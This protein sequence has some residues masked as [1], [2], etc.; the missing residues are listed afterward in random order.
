MMK[1]KNNTSS[2]CVLAGVLFF[3]CAMPSIS[4]AAFLPMP[5]SPS[6]RPSLSTHHPYHHH[7]S[8]AAL[9]STRRFNFFKDMLEKAFEN[10]DN[11]SKDEKLKGQIDAAPEKDDPRRQEN[12]KRSKK[13]LTATQEKWRNAVYG[14]GNQNSAAAAAA[15]TTKQASRSSPPRSFILI[16]GQTYLME[17]FLT[18]VP[19]KDP[20]SDLFGSKVNISSRD[21]QVGL[22]VPEKPSVSDVLIE[23]LPNEKCRC[24]TDTDFTTK[25][26]AAANTGDDDESNGDSGGY[27]DWKLSSDGKQI[28]FRIP[29]QGYTRTVETRGSIQ[30]VYWSNEQDKVRQTSTSYSIPA[31]WMYGEAEF[32]T[33]AKQQAWTNGILKV[34]QTIGM[35]GAG[36]KMVP[37][38]K[39]T[40]KRVIVKTASTTTT[41]TTEDVAPSTPPQVKGPV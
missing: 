36:S 25:A 14:G 24:L 39:F 29:V 12:Q 26:P 22:A 32:V 10:D 33:T 20:S 5:C 34:E 8:R 19:N 15:T 4:V 28:R 30:S 23:F 41:T 3:I 1:K 9:L 37:C 16:E 11:L 35:L 21:R 38:G 13:T 17:F 18:G 7:H 2:S 27:G 40:A 6:F 31:G